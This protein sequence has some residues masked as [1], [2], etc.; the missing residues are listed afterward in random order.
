[1]GHHNVDRTTGPVLRHL[2]TMVT[3][4]L[5]LIL[6]VTGTAGA[7]ELQVPIDESKVFVV[8]QPVTTVAVTNPS[9]ADVSVHNDKII[10]VVGRMYGVTN[11]I[12]LDSDGKPIA[13]KRVRVTSVANAGSVTYVRGPGIFSYSCAPRC[14]RV[15]LPGD[16]MGL[17]GPDEGPTTFS[18]ES[19]EISGRTGQVDAAS[20]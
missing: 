12:A 4:G 16:R 1:M 20:K 18:E 7:S 19:G 17:P 3:L 13:T 14:E 5:A 10:L 9:I 11:I 2:L 15:L 6:S 8:D